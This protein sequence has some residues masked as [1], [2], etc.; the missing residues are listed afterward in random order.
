MQ[1]FLIALWAFHEF[2]DEHNLDIVAGSLMRSF[3]DA[4]ADVRPRLLGLGRAAGLS[5]ED[6]HALETAAAPPES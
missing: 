3:H 6:L 5:D 1:S 2:D 4:P